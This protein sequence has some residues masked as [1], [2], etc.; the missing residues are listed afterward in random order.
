MVD[1]NSF[2]RHRSH[3][4]SSE[5]SCPENRLIWIGRQISV[6]SRAVFSGFGHTTRVILN[7]DVVLLHSFPSTVPSIHGD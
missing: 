5:L 6:W 3:L 1:R 4:S 7:Q 2:Y